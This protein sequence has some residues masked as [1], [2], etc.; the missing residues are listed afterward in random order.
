MASTRRASRSGSGRVS[1]VVS[2]PVAAPASG[3]SRSSC[4]PGKR[5]WWRKRSGSFNSSRDDAHVAALSRATGEHAAKGVGH[6]LG[7]DEEAETPLDLVLEDGPQEVV[8]VA[9]VA[10]DPSPGSSATRSTAST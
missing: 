8:L 2:A 1:P 6:V 5:S 10:V 4:I 3:R 9:G 7:A